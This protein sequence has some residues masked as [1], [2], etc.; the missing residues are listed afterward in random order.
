MKQIDAFWEADKIGFPK[1]L[2]ETLKALSGDE[3]EV[4]HD[5]KIFENEEEM[6]RDL[7]KAEQQDR[8]AIIQSIFPKKKSKGGVRFG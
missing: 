2:A 6:H 8:E 3:F 1:D 4:I 5:E 7:E